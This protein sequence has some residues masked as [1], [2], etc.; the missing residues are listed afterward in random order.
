MG[1]QAG[2]ERAPSPKRKS[3]FLSLEYLF[4]IRSDSPQFVGDQ[5]H[6]YWVDAKVLEGLGPKERK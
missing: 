1:F 5:A 2:F 3:K 4:F 6:F